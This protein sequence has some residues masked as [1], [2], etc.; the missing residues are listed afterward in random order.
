MKPRKGDRV[1]VVSVQDRYGER[2]V[3]RTGSVVYAFPRDY[4]VCLDGDEIWHSFYESELEVIE[5][6]V[7]GL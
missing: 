4:V 6:E 5:K 1:K 2:F 7:N 3:G